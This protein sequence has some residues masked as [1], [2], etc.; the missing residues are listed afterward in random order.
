MNTVK[1]R[2]AGGGWGGV[3]RGVV[4]ERK[5]DSANTDERIKTSKKK[6]KKKTAVVREAGRDPNG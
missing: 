1:Y 3:G 4:R 6:K 5:R 2:T